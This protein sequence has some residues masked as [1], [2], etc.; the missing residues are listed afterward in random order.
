VVGTYGDRDNG[1]IANCF[2]AETGESFLLLYV[3]GKAKDTIRVLNQATFF[4][5]RVFEAEADERNKT[6][7]E[8]ARSIKLTVRGQ[9]Q[10]YRISCNNLDNGTSVFQSFG[11]VLAEA[12][13]VRVFRCVATWS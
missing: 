13:R 3:R 1:F 12:L 6:Y 11:L 5:V 7:P 10:S 8:S 4:G 2:K 9:R